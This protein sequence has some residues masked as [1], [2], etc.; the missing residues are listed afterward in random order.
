MSRFEPAVQ[1]PLKIA[2]INWLF[3]LLLLVLGAIGVAALYSAG[4]GNWWPY[5]GKHAIFFGIGFITLL[6]CGLVSTSRWY[7]WSYVIYGGL[8]AAVVL[9]VIIGHIGMGAQRWLTLGGVNIQPSEFMKLGLILVLARYLSQLSLVDLKLPQALLL[10][11]L[12][13]AVPVIFILKQPNLGTATILVFITLAMFFAA[14]VPWH[15]FAILGGLGLAALPVIWQFG[16]HDYQRGRVLTFLN[17]DRDPLGA[18]YHITQAKIALGSGGLFGKG[19]LQ[20]TQSHLQFL[21][22]AQTDFVISL[23]GEEWG[24]IGTLVVLGLYLMIIA[25][26]LWLASRAR[27]AFTQLLA[28]GLAVNSFLYFA[29]NVGMILGLLP[30]VGIPLPL[31][32]YGGSALLASMIGFGWLLAVDLH[33]HSR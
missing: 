17:P 6:A 33:N 15:R 5:A 8:L 32:S 10:P 25:Y 14:G 13:M 1:V 12:L 7:S 26:G 19:F 21:P 18:G 4:G 2:Q 23:I 11:T 24:L 9:V 20:G 27:T 29:I 31:I 30:V 3:V 28:F 16:L 22:E